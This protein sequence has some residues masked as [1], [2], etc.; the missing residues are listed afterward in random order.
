M[1]AGMFAFDFV[2][3]FLYILGYA[4]LPHVQD[5]ANSLDCGRNP[6]KPILTLLDP[7][8]LIFRSIETI[9]IIDLD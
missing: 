1:D 9:G 3:S 4:T 2:I 6:D 7:G 5:N 8:H